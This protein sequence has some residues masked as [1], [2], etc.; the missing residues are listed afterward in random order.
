LSSNIIIRTLA[1]YTGHNSG[2]STVTNALGAL[3]TEYFRRGFV[4]AKVTVPPQQVTN[5]VVYFQVTE[6]KVAAVKILHNHYFSSN[7]ILSALPYVKTLTNGRRILNS[8]IFQTELDRANSD[9][10]RQIAP[11]IRA[12]IEPGTSALVLDVHDRLPLH[13]RLDFDNYSPPGT[14]ELR[15]NAN[16]SYDNLWQLNHSLGLQYGF[17]PDLLKPSLGEGTHLNLSPIDA[18]DVSYYSGFYRAP[19]GP[20]TGVEKQI[21]QDQTHFGYNETTKQFVVPPATSQPEI[22]VY[23]SRSTT[24]PTIYGPTTTVLDTSQ[25]S[26]EQQLISQ[27]YTVQTTAGGRLSFPMPQWGGIQSTLSFGADYKDDKVVT[28]PTNYFY[29]TTVVTHGNNST[30]APTITHSSIGIP[31]VASY[32]ELNYTPLSVGWSGSHQDRWGQIG[33]PSELWNTIN[34]GVTLQVGTGGTLSK[35]HAFPSLIANSTDATSEFVTI[36]PQISRLQILPDNFSL[37][38]NLSGQW[39]N[40]PLLNLEQFELGGNASIPG[41]REGELYADSG[42]LGQLEL[43]SPVYWRGAGALKFGTQLTAFTDYGQGYDQETPTTLLAHQSLWG[44]GAGLNFHIGA[45]VESHI[46]IAWPMISSAYTTE[47]RERIS[48]SVS[49]QF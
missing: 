35:D 14:P 24:G 16:A 44:V 26:I 3:Q 49:A 45:H 17:S 38:G 22:T 10:D 47:G 19:L 23:A 4:T 6:G 29:Y 48:F 21:A 7:N 13:G 1:P 25:E 43:R 9:P 12:G 31:G 2:I 46:L 34:G 41:Y 11:E 37:Y 40:E 18:P 8:K 42:W 39:G 30:A 33:R 5:K 36:R 20:L 28:L 15:V 27:Q 32:P